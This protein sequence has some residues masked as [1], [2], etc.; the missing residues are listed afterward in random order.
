MKLFFV[1]VAIESA[2]NIPEMNVQGISFQF[3]VGGEHKINSSSII[4]REWQH[5]RG[6]SMG[7]IL[8]FISRSQTKIKRACFTQ[9]KACH[10]KDIIKS[11]GFGL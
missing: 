5:L 3:G 2:E 8:Q 7:Q 6:E 4:L 9:I 10:F 11:G 1:M